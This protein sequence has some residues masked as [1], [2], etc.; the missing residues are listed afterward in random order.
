MSCGRP[1]HE[2]VEGVCKH[3]LQQCRQRTGHQLG[4]WRR[5]GGVRASGHESL[6]DCDRLLTLD[7]CKV[8]GANAVRMK[9]LAGCCM[10]AQAR[11]IAQP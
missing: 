3:G 8:A 4:R 6:S 1:R 10:P 5:R 2:E 7:L 11:Q 9:G